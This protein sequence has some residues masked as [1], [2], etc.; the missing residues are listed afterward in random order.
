MH[1]E[2]GGVIPGLQ[3]LNQPSRALINQGCTVLLQSPLGDELVKF[4]GEHA[5]PK[6]WRLSQLAGIG[7]ELQYTDCPCF[8]LT[9]CH[10]SELSGRQYARGLGFGAMWL[11]V[12]VAIGWFLLP[13]A[14]IAALVGVLIWALDLQHH[15]AQYLRRCTGPQPEGLEAYMGV[16]VISFDEPGELFLLRE[17][18]AKS[19]AGATL[20]TRGL[21]VNKHTERIVRLC[22]PG[23]LYN[24]PWLRMVTNGVLD[25][26]VPLVVLS[27][28]LRDVAPFVPSAA[29]MLQYWFGRW[30]GLW[31]AVYR[32]ACST[33][34]MLLWWISPLWE[35]AARLWGVLGSICSSPIVAH[36]L[37]LM[38]M[39][40]AE[41]ATKMYFLQAK[42]Q[43][44]Q[45]LLAHGQHVLQWGLAPVASLLRYGAGV[46][47]PLTS[48]LGSLYSAALSVASSAARPLA[49]VLRLAGRGLS[50]LSGL[51]PWFK[52]GVKV[53][54]AATKST[55]AA[56][57][58][59]GQLA[60]AFKTAKT[61]SPRLKNAI[62]KVLQLF[63]K[64]NK[65]RTPQSPLLSPHTPPLTPRVLALTSPGPEPMVLSPRH[66]PQLRGSL[67]SPRPRSASTPLQG[68]PR[69]RPNPAP[70]PMAGPANPVEEKSPGSSGRPKAN[71]RWSQH[72]MRLRA[73]NQHNHNHNKQT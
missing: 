14:G 61:W 32:A 13:Q 70:E 36:F 33:Y 44:L 58:S 46:L 71:S 49:A 37:S 30:F 38:E 60:E 28:V 22:I 23:A 68:T 63:N 21:I 7:V 2:L 1:R 42:L 65:H 45:K 72:Y 9:L 51:L 8:A 69:S 4:R 56:A 50:Q 15:V 26:G 57:K 11:A 16:D 39:L 41:F 20:V 17:A 10:K 27:L 31:S 53:G 35:L 25:F 59:T 43:A 12:L 40:A 66:C 55:G 47:A 62:D 18:L 3:S 29:V 19:R 5:A 52:T 6:R 67:E 34:S 48:V 73:S 54:A 64:A 24:Q